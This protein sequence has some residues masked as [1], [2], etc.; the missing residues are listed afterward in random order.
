MSGIGKLAELLCGVEVP[1]RSRL[2]QDHVIDSGHGWFDLNQTFTARAI[3][4]DV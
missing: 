2:T 3:A 4:A 1:V